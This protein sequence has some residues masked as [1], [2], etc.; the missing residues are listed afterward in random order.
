VGF[1]HVAQIFTIQR[2]RTVIKTG[3]TTME[4][5]YGITSRP[6][7]KATPE[8]IL[9]ANRGHWSIEN[10]SHYVRD[11]AYDEDRSQIRTKNGPWVMA[12]LRNFAISLLRLIGYKS[13]PE[14]NR[15]MAAK[16]HLTL[17]LVGA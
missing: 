10:R 9:A 4:T 13:I 8:Q 12:T 2:E 11:G 17:R 5:A 15:D 1:P 6:P 14:G 7:E 16:P 3:K